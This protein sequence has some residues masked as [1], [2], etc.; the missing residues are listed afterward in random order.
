MNSHLADRHTIRLFLAGDVMIGRGIDQILP[1]PSAPQPDEP[2]VSSAYEYVE[3]A[4]RAHGRIVAP[5]ELS[6]IWET[7]SRSSKVAARCCAS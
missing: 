1:H 4:E 3:L 2:Y 5:P 7:S 6:Y